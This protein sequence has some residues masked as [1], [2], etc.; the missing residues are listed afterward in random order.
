MLSAIGSIARGMARGIGKMGGETMEAGPRIAE[1]IATP[2]KLA[3]EKPAVSQSLVPRVL[4]IESSAK[5]GGRGGARG[6]LQEISD[7]KLTDNTTSDSA[8]EEAQQD[9][10]KREFA[11]P[12]A[13]LPTPPPQPSYPGEGFNVVSK[14]LE[15]LPEAIGASPTNVEVKAPQGR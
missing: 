9:L 13:G 11:D 7:G 12:F 6:G 3:I 10:S 1:K 5:K 15:E 4:D 8:E 2:P 14:T